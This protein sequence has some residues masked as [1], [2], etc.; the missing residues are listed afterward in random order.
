MY[1]NLTFMS[2]NVLFLYTFLGYIRA[3]DRGCRTR[4]GVHD[5]ILF[6]GTVGKRII[7]DYAL[8][9][10]ALLLS[11]FLI[12]NIFRSIILLQRINFMILYKPNFFSIV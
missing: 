12:I 10:L 1:A 3:G 2:E 7:N 11:I 8:Y 9:S 5:F 6:P 4:A